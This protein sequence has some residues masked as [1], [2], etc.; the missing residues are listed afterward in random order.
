MMTLAPC[1]TGLLQELAPLMT[2][3]SF[4]TSLTIATGWV[5]ARRRTVTGMIQSAGAVGTKHHSAFH[6]FFA[7][8]RWSLDVIGLAVFDLIAPWAD[9]TVMLATLCHTSVCN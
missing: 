7:N 5:F 2:A 1:F 6:R 8:A 3:P 9:E 4:Q